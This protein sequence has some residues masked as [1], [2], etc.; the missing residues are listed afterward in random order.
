MPLSHDWEEV[1]ELKDE[2]IDPVQASA[3]PQPGRNARVFLSESS[4]EEG[5]GVD[6][7]VI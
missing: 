4:S 6:P 3:S 2:G 7:A 1:P 5:R